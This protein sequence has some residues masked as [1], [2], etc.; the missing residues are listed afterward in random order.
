M[1][2]MLFFAA[3]VFLSSYLSADFSKLEKDD[4]QK[5]INRLND[6]FQERE[7]ELSVKLI[8]WSQWDDMY[9]FAQDRNQAFIDSNFPNETF[10]NLHVNFAIVINKDNAVVYEKFVDNAGNEQPFPAGLDSYITQGSPLVTF[11]GISDGKQGV[12]MTSDEKPMIVAAQP[13][14]SSDRTAPPNGVV[15]FGYYFDSDAA[16]LLSRL[17]STS[18]AFAPYENGA[19]PDDFSQARG[20]LSLANPLF[21]ESSTRQ[22]NMVYGY[23]LV[24]DVFG[25]PVLILRSGTDRS[26]FA[27]G[28]ETVRL[29]LEIMLGMA[30]LFI[31]IVFSLFEFLVIRKTS[32]L[33]RGVK[34]I[35]EGGT[36]QTTLLEIRGKDEFSELGREIN[37]ML[38]ARQ[39]TDARKLDY[40]KDI[41]RM[42]NLMVSREL[43]MVELKKEVANLKN[44]THV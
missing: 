28:Q 29:F 14:T 17:T 22:A 12:I 26:I 7:N 33:S 40:I 8:D 6:V 1:L 35:S 15:M 2:S 41:E 23:G 38:Q 11:S 3:A 27:K 42:N 37:K 9:Q 31:A 4:A 5:N 25:S 13:I 21:V 20:N 44:N 18:V 16:S 10:A 36:N 43:K 30:I 24:T 19:T 39:V 32:Q 34:G